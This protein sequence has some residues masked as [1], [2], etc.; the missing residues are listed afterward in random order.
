M[1][2]SAEDLTV[3]WRTLMSVASNYEMGSIGEASL[4]EARRLIEVEMR[5]QHGDNAWEVMCDS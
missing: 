3:T 2:I 5:A 1:D 4:I